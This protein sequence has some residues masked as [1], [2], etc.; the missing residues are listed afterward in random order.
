MDEIRIRIRAELPAYGLII[1]HAWHWH[2]TPKCGVAD[3]EGK[4]HA[5]GRG[6]SVTAATWPLLEG[7]HSP[8]FYSC[9]SLHRKT[10]HS[11]ER[12]SLT[13][14]DGPFVP[15]QFGWKVRPSHHSIAC[16]TS[17]SKSTIHTA[18]LLLVELPP[19]LLPMH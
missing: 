19:C 4:E 14:C 9:I 8:L 5:S 16:S 13:D 10:K 15:G 1:M 18:T 11:G 2:G 3:R 17:S 6:L 7:T 12:A